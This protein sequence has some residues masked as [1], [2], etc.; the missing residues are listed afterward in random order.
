[1]HVIYAYQQNFFIAFFVQ[2]GD[3]HAK[4]DLPGILSHN[5]I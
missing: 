3:L 1:M 4:Y 5:S 2:E